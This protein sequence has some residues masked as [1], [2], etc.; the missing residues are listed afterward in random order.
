MQY[1]CPEGFELNRVGRDGDLPGATEI[2]WIKGARTKVL[3]EPQ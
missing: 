1:I 2:I 3:Q